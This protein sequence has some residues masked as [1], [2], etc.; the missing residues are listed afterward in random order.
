M[1]IDRWTKKPTLHSCEL[2][3]IIGGTERQCNEDMVAIP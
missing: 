3:I 2:S 1:E